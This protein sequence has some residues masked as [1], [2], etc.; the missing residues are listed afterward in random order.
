MTRP[1]ILVAMLLVAATVTSA[2]AIDTYTIRVYVQGTTTLVTST[3]Q[4]AAS[5]PCNLTPITP[6]SP[7]PPNAT[8]VYWTNPADSTKQCRLSMVNLMS[9]TSIKPGTY[10]VRM[11][12]S[13][14]GQAAPE[15][16]IG[17]YIKAGPPPALAGVFTAN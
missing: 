2:Q 16:N 3:S 5:T 9:P 14:T 10:D 6:P 13:V 12:A 8:Y 7:T 11:V 15:S 17:E 1:L 4:S